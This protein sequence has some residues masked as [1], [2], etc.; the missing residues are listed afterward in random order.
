MQKLVASQKY[1]MTS[2]AFAPV[3][4]V[5]LVPPANFQLL[6]QLVIVAGPPEAGWMISM[7]PD[8]PAHTLVGDAIVQEHEEVKSVTEKF[9]PRLRLA[10]NVVVETVNAVTARAVWF[11]AASISAFDVPP[12]IFDAVALAVHVG[13]VVTPPD[14]RIEP[15]ATSASLDHVG[16]VA[17]A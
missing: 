17:E 11:P 4:S 10:V 6:P 7:N 14:M 12:Q 3:E 1:G 9:S 16:V 5:G 15:V 13:A 8:A 2:L